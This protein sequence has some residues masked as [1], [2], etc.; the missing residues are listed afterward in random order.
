MI[1]KRCKSRMGLLPV[2]SPRFRTLGEGTA[3]GTY[4]ERKTAQA[5]A[6]IRALEA[7][8]ALYDFDFL[9]I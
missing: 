4:H 9:K 3:G 2:C 1:E 7:F 8:A 5:A 6:V